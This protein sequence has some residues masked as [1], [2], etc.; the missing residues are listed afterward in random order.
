ME[1]LQKNI[2][3]ILQFIDS[4]RVMASSVSNLANNF[5]KEIYKIKCKYK[6]DDKKFQTS[7]IHV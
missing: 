7:K 3:Y 1:K 4:P 5:S 2:S 6:H